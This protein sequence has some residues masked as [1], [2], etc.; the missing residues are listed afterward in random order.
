MVTPAKVPFKLVRLSCK[1]PRKKFLLDNKQ[2]VEVQQDFYW[3][4]KICYLVSCWIECGM[5]FVVV[6]VCVCVCL[7]FQARSYTPSIKLNYFML[8]LQWAFTP[9][10]NWSINH[11]PA[12]TYHAHESVEAWKHQLQVGIFKSPWVNRGHMM[13][14]WSSSGTRLTF[15]LSRKNLEAIPS[16]LQ[17]CFNFPI[18]RIFTNFKADMV[19]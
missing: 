11:I 16:K 18:L 15:Q 10:T 1:S 4:P 3:S 8:F 5:G 13:M 9:G 19:R 2:Y 7:L 6:V 14:F 12:S 17:I